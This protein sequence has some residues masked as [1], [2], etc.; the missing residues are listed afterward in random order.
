MRLRSRLQ[1]ELVDRISQHVPAAL[2]TVWGYKSVVVAIEQLTLKPAGDT[3]TWNKCVAFEGI[4]RAELHADNIDELVIE[5]L[6]CDLIAAP[7]IIPALPVST[8]E[9]TEEGRA[10]L[11]EMRD[12]MRDQQVVMTLRFR[13]EGNFLCA[14]EIITRPDLMV[15]LAP[16]IGPENAVDYLP[17]AEV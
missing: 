12:A 5:P 16:Q 2:E 10:N 14:S 9:S 17:V 8:G 11:F 7:M 3:D 15:G 4:V 13:A 1:A 6:V